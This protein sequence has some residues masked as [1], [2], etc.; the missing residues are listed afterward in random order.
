MFIHL[1]SIEYFS[2]IGNGWRAAVLNYTEQANFIRMAQK[3]I[4]NN[5]PY[6]IGGST[7]NTPSSSITDDI[8]HLYIKDDS[9]SIICT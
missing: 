1:S 7:N 6:F 9:G 3:S 2:A 4:I 5:I 8:F